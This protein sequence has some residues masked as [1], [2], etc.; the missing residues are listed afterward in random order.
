M[1]RYGLG[2]TY[3][4]LTMYLYALFYY[5]KAVK[6]RPSDA[7][8]W[9]ALASCY[10]KVRPLFACGAPSQAATPRYDPLP[11]PPNEGGRDGGSEQ[12]GSEGG[13]NEGRV[14]REDDGAL[15]ASG[16]ASGMKGRTTVS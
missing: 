5:R 2:Q 16:L 9:C 7:R 1:R 14:Q 10:A 4:I 15:L 8:M 13:G 3:E 11:P 12:G 6:L